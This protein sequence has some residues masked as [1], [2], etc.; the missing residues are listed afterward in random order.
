MK[1]IC[2]LSIASII[3]CAAENIDTCE[4]QETCLRAEVTLDD[5][6]TCE[7]KICVFYDGN[8]HPVTGLDTCLKNDEAISHFCLEDGGDK[9]LCIPQGSTLGDCC[10]NPNKC[11]T[12]VNCEGLCCGNCDHGREDDETCS[13]R[14]VLNG[15][16]ADEASCYGLI[17]CTTLK[18]GETK[19][20]FALKDGNLG[21]GSCGA[22]ASSLGSNI[23]IGGETAT[24]NC[25]SN[26]DYCEGGNTKECEWSI[27]IPVDPAC[28]GAPGPTTCPHEG[29]DAGLLDELCSLCGDCDK[30]DA[31]PSDA[32][33]FQQLPQPVDPIGF[34][35]VPKQ[36]YNAVYVFLIVLFVMVT[37][38]I[39]LAF[40]K[41][42]FVPKANHASVKHVFDEEDA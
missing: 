25:G 4:G 22:A 1:L 16:A 9:N 40:K 41:F 21:E 35:Q 39:L 10:G 2:I 24:F 30:C 32:V 13:V 5:P 42:L 23:I 7:Y 20:L 6:S 8:P 37:M 11:E 3:G 29:D 15:V 27:T 14:G 31:S 33:P 36:I 26:S 28:V 19:S 38:V 17:K 18:A 34:V 12:V